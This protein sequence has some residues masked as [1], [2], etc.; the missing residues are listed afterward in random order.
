MLSA[1][2]STFCMKY[3]FPALTA[4]LFAI[5]TGCLWFHTGKTDNDFQPEKQLLAFFKWVFPIMGIAT[6]AFGI[7]YGK[8]FKCVAID[9]DAVYVS[10]FFKPEVRIPFAEIKNCWF[11]YS[12]TGR[13]SG[14]TL[15]NI[16]FQNPSAYGKQITFIMKD[17]W[18]P[19][20]SLVAELRERGDR[21]RSQT[22]AQSGT[23]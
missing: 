1:N 2:T 3:F 12:S 10:I 7:W 14:M 8:R 21:A 15:I 20:H 16:E 17:P 19:S 13:K 9:D 6:T 11:G 22:N 5:V 23:S 18:N 4:V